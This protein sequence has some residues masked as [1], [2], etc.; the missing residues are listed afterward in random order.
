MAWNNYTVFPP[1][2]LDVGTT[3]Y[4]DS[5]GVYPDDEDDT[6]MFQK[7]FPIFTVRRTRKRKIGKAPGFDSWWWGWLHLI[8]AI[9]RVFAVSPIT[10]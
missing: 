10:G 5:G 6:E 1:T 7:K 2:A 4:W 8:P 9:P 3:L